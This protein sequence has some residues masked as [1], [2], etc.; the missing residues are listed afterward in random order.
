MRNIDNIEDVY[1]DLN[2]I[3]REKI[4]SIFNQIKVLGYAIYIDDAINFSKGKHL[5][6]YPKLTYYLDKWVCTKIHH[7]NKKELNYDK[8]I[9]LLIIAKNK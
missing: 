5:K 9:E 3:S 4:K 2:K 8:F 1:I 7:K 6:R